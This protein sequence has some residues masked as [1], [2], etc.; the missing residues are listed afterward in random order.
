MEKSDIG[1]E[2]LTDEKNIIHRIK[3]SGKAGI[4]QRMEKNE[5]VRDVKRTKY[6]KKI[7]K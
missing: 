3:I 7:N 1:L 5:S 2:T 4:I 6:V